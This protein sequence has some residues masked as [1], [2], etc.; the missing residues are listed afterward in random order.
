M[1]QVKS[2]FLLSREMKELIYSDATIARIQEM[3]ENDGRAYLREDVLANP[4][5]FK[6]VEIGFS[7]WGSPKLDAELLAALPS[8][9]A[10]F[11][12]AGSVRSFV[13]EAFWERDIVLTSAYTANAV[14][15]A[16]YTVA[17]MNLSLKRVW[18]LNNALRGGVHVRDKQGIPGMFTGSKVGVIS[19]GAIG[20]LVCNKLKD[21]SID[22]YAYDPFV[23]DEV[24]ESCGASKA[25]SLD[26]IFSECDVISLHTP[27]L[28]ETENMIGGNHFRQMRSGST[29]L[30][31]SRGMVV[32]ESA[33]IRV[34]TERSDIYAIIDVIQNESEY[35]A[36]PLGKLPNVFLTPHIAG[37]MGRECHR[38]GA[39]AAEECARYLRDEPQMTQITREKAALLA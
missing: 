38:M 34:L 12:G 37:S 18:A 25:D 19:L 20:Q 26:W 2:I 24:F 6:E 15:V 35:R 28:P 36:S 10:Y 1:S 14:P 31:T 16:E 11:Y 22:V 5:A 21:Y 7:G 9:K 13:T 17:M 27:W 29:F 23:C 3:T 8:L 30:N 39:F 33:M 4:E 32:D